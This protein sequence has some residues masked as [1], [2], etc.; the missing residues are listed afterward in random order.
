MK[1]LVDRN[2]LVTGAAQGMGFAIARALYREGARV[3]LMDVNEDAVAAA[4]KDIDPDGTRAAGRR[5]DVTKADE[6]RALVGELKAR[7]GSVD[8]L[9]NNAGGA[10]HTPH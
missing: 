10:L 9:I 6:V 2:A 3:L 4:A 7:W 1:R 8:I 5:G